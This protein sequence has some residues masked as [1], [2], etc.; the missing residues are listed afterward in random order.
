MMREA[1]VNAKNIF[2]ARALNLKTSVTGPIERSSI[3]PTQLHAGLPCKG[4]LNCSEHYSALN[5]QATSRQ[6]TSLHRCLVSFHLPYGR[7]EIYM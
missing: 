2:T 5:L 7:T 3:I 6:T 4:C 1:S